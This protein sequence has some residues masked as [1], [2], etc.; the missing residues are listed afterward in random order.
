MSLE[1][2][3]DQ[4]VKFLDD[5]NPSDRDLLLLISNLIFDKVS[6]FEH[7]DSIFKIAEEP[8]VDD[9]TNFILV[10][11]ALD[12]N[13]DSIA[14]NASK[15]AHVLLYLAGKIKIYENRLYDTN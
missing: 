12:F 1:A 8:L 7:L 5:A 6:N 13:I 11:E 10:K 15:A 2:T 4:L 3:Y 14:L 9:Y